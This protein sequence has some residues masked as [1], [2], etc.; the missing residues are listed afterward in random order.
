M[1]L[2]AAL[3]LALPFR[4][5]DGYTAQP[6]E[7]ISPAKAW[8]VQPPAGSPLQSLLLLVGEKHLSDSDLDRTASDWHAAHVRNR[9]AWGVHIAGWRARESISVG[10]RRGVRFRD[11]VSAAL[12]ASEQTMTCVLAGSQLGCVLA[13]APAAARGQVDLLSTQLLASLRR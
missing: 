5:P 2:V 3:A 13:S 6:A 4:L 7:D 9:A 1:W 12:G 8:R 11:R 10:G